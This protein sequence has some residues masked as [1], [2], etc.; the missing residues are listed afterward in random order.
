AAGEKHTC[1]LREDGRVRCW[2]TNDSGELGQGHREDIGDNELPSSL[3]DV[4]LG[5]RAMQI[6]AQDDHTCALLEDGAVRCWGQ[7]RSG[8]L[9]QG[10]TQSIGDDEL[11]ASVDV[12]DVGGRVVEIAA[13]RYHTCALLEEGTLR[14]WGSNW[15]GQLGY[16]HTR[17][18][19][20]NELPV[21]VS[22]V[23]Y[24]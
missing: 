19:G 1:A 13:G 16:G 15:A 12:V 5:S 9:G 24:R 4:E 10:H 8:E 17:L 2:G 7:N 18:I 20:D 23:S 3:P 11:P 6:A 22:P 14:C 21:S